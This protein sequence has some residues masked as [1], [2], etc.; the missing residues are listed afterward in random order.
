MYV[1]S[2][3]MFIFVYFLY[4]SLYMY[5][6]Y[7]HG[8]VCVFSMLMFKKMMCYNYIKFRIEPVLV[9]PTYTFGIKFIF[10]RVKWRYSYGFWECVQIQN[11]CLC[12][13]VCV[14]ERWYELGNNSSSKIYSCCLWIFFI[15]GQYVSYPH[16]FQSESVFLQNWTIQ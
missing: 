8:H 7:I 3:Y 1:I 6:L 13:C 5:Y 14:Y 2:I 10:H 4:L 15:F 9:I 16:S 11:I 12:V